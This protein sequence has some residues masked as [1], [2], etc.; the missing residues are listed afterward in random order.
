M[1]ISDPSPRAP[2]WFLIPL[3]VLLVTLIVGLLSFAVSLLLGICAVALS[4]KLH[5]LNP[6][7]T[8]A[9][10]IIALPTAGVV[11]AVVLGSATSLE[12]RHYRR[13]RTL[14]EMERQMG[15]N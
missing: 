12:L 14:H 10:R 8:S 7:L 5:H 1:P 3:R 13:A 6:N 9:Y 4:A 11:A 2:R 15:G